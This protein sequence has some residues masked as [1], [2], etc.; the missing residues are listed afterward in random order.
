M[1][2]L[3]ALGG[4]QIQTSQELTTEFTSLSKASRMLLEEACIGLNLLLN[5]PRTTKRSKWVTRPPLRVI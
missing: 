2:D 4:E 1:T 5:E 3:A